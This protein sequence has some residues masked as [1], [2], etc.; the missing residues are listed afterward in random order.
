[1]RSRRIAELSAIV[2]VLCVVVLVGLGVGSN[3]S[4]A[5]NGTPAPE[6]TTI[7]T[8]TP[9][10]F[11]IPYIGKSSDT[12]SVA[13]PSTDTGSRA[14][15][16]A[17]ITLAL[18]IAG[19]IVLG[20]I[21]L[22]LRRHRTRWVP[23]LLALL[24]VLLL[25]IAVVNSDYAGSS[26]G[27]S[28]PPPRCI[29]S[30][31]TV[32]VTLDADCSFVSRA[33]EHWTLEDRLPANPFFVVV[34]GRRV[35]AKTLP[36]GFHYELGLA[37]CTTDD[38]TQTYIGA[39]FTAVRGIVH[40]RDLLVIPRFTHSATFVDNATGT[41]G[42]LVELAEDWN[43]SPPTSPATP[44]SGSS[45]LQVLLWVVTALGVVMLIASAVLLG[46]RYWRGTKTAIDDL[47][48]TE[49]ATEKDDEDVLVSAEAILEEEADPRTAIL[50]CWLELERL[51][52]STGFERGPSETPDELTARLIGHGVSASAE[53][54]ALHDLF[55]RA[56]FSTH[57]FDES[58][59]DVARRGLIALRESWSRTEPLASE[60]L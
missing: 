19:V 37:R 10:V 45:I 24:A 23:L 22:L 13:T 20:L 33:G 2:L 9:N 56:R 38:C 39:Q 29:S 41:T 32:D 5:K 44:G 48:E 36:A 59:R 25:A 3:H 15:S 6:T 21:L 26:A 17:P 52:A 43:R 18:A 51:S 7:P 40:K 31:A 53:L 12:F 49:A 54:L 42:W 4:S 46:R 58:D 57:E 28:P 14:S 27:Q 50:L 55:V 30:G 35:H 16:H 47:T 1:M 8:V 11:G 34:D 60:T